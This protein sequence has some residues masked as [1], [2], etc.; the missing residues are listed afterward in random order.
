MRRPS[1]A[2]TVVVGECGPGHL[3]DRL[4][5]GSGRP[6]PI[7]RRERLLP[8][9]G[10]RPVAVHCASAP[11]LGAPTARMSAATITGVHAVLFTKDA[12]RL[13]AFFR[14]VLGLSSADAG[15]GWLIFALPPAELAAHPTDE[16]VTMSS[17]SCA[18]TFRRPL[19]NGNGV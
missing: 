19:K 2:R 1:T 10:Q 3:H 13:R 11:T 6:E 18:T 16:E 8:L 7:S 17:T 12:E 15:G 9:L 4:L 5:A 14:D